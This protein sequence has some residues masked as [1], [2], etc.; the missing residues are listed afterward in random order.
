MALPR[1]FV[2]HFTL[3]GRGRFALPLDAR[4]I[5]EDFQKGRSTWPWGSYS[6]VGDRV[7]VAPIGLSC[8]RILHCVS[9]SDEVSVV[10]VTATSVVR[11]AQRRFS[12]AR[13]ATVILGQAL[14]ATLLLHAIEAAAENIKITI[15]GSGGPLGGI[16]AIGSNTGLVKGYVDFPRS[17]FPCLPNGLLDARGTLGERGNLTVTLHNSS[18]KRLKVRPVQLSRGNI[19]K[20]VETYLAEARKL[21]S[22][23]SFGVFL[24]KQGTITC[25]RGY[26][27]QALPSVSKMTLDRMAK[28][29]RDLPK[30]NINADEI[31]ELLFQGIGRRK[32]IRTINPR[33]G[34]C[35]L[36]M[37]QR[38]LENEISSKGFWQIRQ[39]LK[40]KGYI[41][42]FCDACGEEYRFTEDEL[43]ELIGKS[44]SDSE[45]EE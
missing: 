40:S 15:V 45:E 29:T 14:M 42:A 39:A 20:G 33:F 34:P 41:E 12:T 24:D 10:S 11:E 43:G 4:P 1:F 5:A 32:T 25:A 6:V 28:N 35:G 44:I 31:C 13:A 30:W 23:A 17:D 8:D 36:E 18:W 16:T 38:I 19:S 37:K 26:V 9:E 2:R 7:P 3:G 21:H 27:Y 22:F